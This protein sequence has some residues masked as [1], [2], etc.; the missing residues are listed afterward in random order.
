MQVMYLKWIY[1]RIYL[2]DLYYHP[3]DSVPSVE[4]VTGADI[5]VLLG[6]ATSSHLEIGYW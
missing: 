3:C 2:F 1:F 4:H 5:L 6:L